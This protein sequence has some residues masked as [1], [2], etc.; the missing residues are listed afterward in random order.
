MIRKRDPELE[1]RLR[2]LRAPD[3]AGAEDRSWAVVQEAYRQRTAVRSA[4]PKRRLALAVAGGLAVIAVGLSPAGAAVGDFVSDVIETGE[5]DAR[6]Q[7]RALPAAGELLVRSGAGPWIVRA[8][9]SKRLLGD[10][11]D[12]TWSP[13]GVFVAVSSGRQ[14]AAL[15]VDGDVR[16]TFPAPGRVRDPRWAGDAEDTRIAYR[17]GDD[18]RVIAGDGDPATDRPI[19]RDVAPVAP[20]WRPIGHAKLGGPAFA[21]S[22]VDRSGRIRTVDPDTGAE[23]E[24]TRVDRRRISPPPGAKGRTQRALSPDAGRVAWVEHLGARDRVMITKQGG[25]GS[26]LFSARGRLTG[27]TWSP[28]GRWLLVGWP[29]ADQWLFLDTQRPKRLVPFGQ[30]SRQFASA[31]EVPAGFPK[32]AGWI[33]PER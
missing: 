10:Y 27:P 12:A 16:W 19:A 30:I 24:T 23:L 33:L 14:L 22:Y 8:D 32:V 21:L 20:A 15:E 5:P 29:A 3:E 28:D 13:H 6:P 17:S 9:G 31:G 26:V 11:D 7:L 1:R 2:G 25:G 18:L 4:S